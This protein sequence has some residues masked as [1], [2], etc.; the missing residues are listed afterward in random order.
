MHIA[1]YL[2]AFF[3]LDLGLAV[4]LGKLIKRKGDNVLDA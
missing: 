4:F 3:V 2:F 1:A